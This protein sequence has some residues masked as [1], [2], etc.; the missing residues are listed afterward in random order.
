MKHTL[1]SEGFDQDFA[2]LKLKNKSY[3]N[4]LK[5]QEVQHNQLAY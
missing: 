1:Q 3:L 4:K 5:I 2:F